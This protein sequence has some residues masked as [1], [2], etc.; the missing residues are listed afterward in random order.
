MPKVR[1]ALMSET[2]EQDYAAADGRV[3]PS[4][5]RHGPQVRDGLSYV[6]N[7]DPFP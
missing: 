2:L 5:E 6:R 1:T 4:G 3:V 7:G